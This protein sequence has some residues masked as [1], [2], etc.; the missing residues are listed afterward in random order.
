ME[1]GLIYSGKDPRQMRA[2]DSL[3]EYLRNRGILADI[4]ET[5]TDVKSPTV[6]IDGHTLTDERRRPRKDQP[7]M[8]PNA[9]DIIAALERHVW[10]L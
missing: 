8:Y 6:I 9:K 10:C 3:R 4:T 7:A 2:R 5:E 1:I